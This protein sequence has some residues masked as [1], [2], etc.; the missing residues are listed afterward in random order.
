MRS[1]ETSI[2]EH[3]VENE[4]IMIEQTEKFLKNLSEPGRTRLTSADYSLY[5]PQLEKIVGELESKRTGLTP[6]E[7]KQKIEELKNLIKSALSPVTEGHY[8]ERASK[9]KWSHHGGTLVPMQEKVRIAHGDKPIPMLGDEDYESGKK[10]MKKKSGE[11][12][13][14]SEDDMIDTKSSGL[15]YALNK[16]REKMSRTPRGKLYELLVRLDVL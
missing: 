5:L 11:L 4:K 7:D 2:E 6:E 8:E 14:S 3:E 15:I 16:T 1:A 10:E 13:N 9:E 12:A